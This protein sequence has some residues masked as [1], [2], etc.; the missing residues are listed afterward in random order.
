[1]L[2]R[3]DILVNR[4]GDIKE[5]KINPVTHQGY[6]YET[7]NALLGYGRGHNEDLLTNQIDSHLKSS[8][9]FKQYDIVK[10]I[11]QGVTTEINQ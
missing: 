1:M 5:W 6:L 8:N 2:Q 7:F 9:S 3:G 10:V 11:R 4:N